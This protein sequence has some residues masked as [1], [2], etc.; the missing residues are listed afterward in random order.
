MATAEEYRSASAALFDQAVSELDSGDV[1]QSSEKFWGAAAQ[2]L[3]SAAERRGWG[4]GS[5]AQ[6]YGIVRRL[7]NELDDDD[8]RR[9]FAVAA[10]LHSNFYENWLEEGDVRT[11]AEDVRELINRLETE[12]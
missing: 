7:S 12:S 6:F 1:R 4:H 8:L 9:Y 10:E 2:A 3:K 11:R 5:H